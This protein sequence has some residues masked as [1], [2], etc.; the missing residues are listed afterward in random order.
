MAYNEYNKYR[1]AV[2]ITAVQTSDALRDMDDV[3]KIPAIAELRLDYLRKPNLERLVKF[4]PAV[5]I[6][7][8]R[9]RSEGGNFMGEEEKRAAYLQ[10]AIHLRAEYVD[11]EF[12]YLHLLRLDEIKIQPPTKLIVS[13]HNFKET[14]GNLE[15]IYKRIADTRADIVKMATRANSLADSSRM[16]DLVAEKSSEK[17]IIGICMGENGVGTRISGPAYGGY[18]T[19]A[20]LDKGKESAPGQMTVQELKDTWKFLG[21]QVKP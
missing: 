8:N 13:Y 17:D 14:P 9:A 18:L 11:I 4:H 1:I 21:P 19:F 7:T 16:L 3:A 15:E 12:A 10:Y 6:V 20:S 2:P 5:K